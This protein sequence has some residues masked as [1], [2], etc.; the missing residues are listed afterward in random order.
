MNTLTYR[1]RYDVVEYGDEKASGDTLVA[2]IGRIETAFQR[3][4]RDNPLNPRRGWF[5]GLTLEYA[6][7]R[8]GGAET[9]AK[10]TINNV[11]YLPV[12]QSI[13]LAIGARG[14]YAWELGAKKRVLT[15]ELFRLRDYT[16]PRGY[17]LGTGDSGNV[18]LN[19]SVEVRFPL[20]KWIGG[21]VFSDFGRVS[22][23]FS[24]LDFQ[25]TKAAV[26]LGFRFITPIGPLRLDYGYPIR[27]GEDR[28]HWPIVAFGHAF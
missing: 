16:T 13:V 15:P 9:F 5:H 23:G 8:L 18:M 3:D 26:G 24:D 19:G 6:D 2:K 14:G 7:S 17:D 20:Y 10:F 11:Y 22:D 28:K 12:S 1:Y 21:A 25:S 4:G 27:E